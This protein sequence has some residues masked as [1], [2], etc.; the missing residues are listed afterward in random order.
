MT[1]RWDRNAVI[2]QIYPRS[3]FDENGDGVG[4]L[5]GIT[6]KL[7][8][9]ASLGVDAIWIS[10]FFKSP[11]KDFGYDV[12]DPRDVDPIFG[13]LDDF[14]RLLEAAHERDLKVLIDQVLSHTSDQ[15]EWF[16]ESR[17]S[18]TNARADWYVWVDPR[19]DGTP[20]N[21]WLSVFG[22]SAWQWEPR[23]GQYYLHNFLAEQ[24]D[25]NLHVDAVQKALLDDVRFWLDRGVDGFRLDAINF[26]F[27][28]LE[29]R[30]N[31]ALPL[32]R[33]RVDITSAANPHGFQEHV[34]GSNRPEVLDFLA[35]LRTLFDEYDAITSVG[36]IGASDAIRLARDYTAPGRLHMTYTFELLGPDGSASTLRERIE[37]QETGIGEGWMCWSVGNHDVT[38]VRSRWSEDG[39]HT[40]TYLTLLFSLRG[41]C[42]LYQGDELGLPE[43]DV[44][45]DRLQDPYGITFWPEFKGRD[46]CRTPIP[47]R[48]DAPEAGFTTATPWLPIPDTHRALAVDRQDDDSVLAHVRE[49]LA[50]RP[51]FGEAP[52]HFREAP[53][54]VL[55]FE[56]GDWVFAFNLGESSAE[57]TLGD[58]EDAG[59]P[60]AVSASSVVKLSPGEF[61]IGR[62]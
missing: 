6:E 46:G 7:D 53:N 44:P 49:F 1:S 15:H 32:E 37:A 14:D 45:Y 62:R 10:P 48:A 59:A 33:R 21:N 5:A 30:S 17:S 27:H 61:A 4:D 16:V 25:L 57:V 51:D 28:D 3:F 13:T 22:G 39:R 26:A 19:P 11:M 24:P 60:G 8:Y 23:R 9:V 31:P 38:R 18:K 50:W 42:C 29:L 36:E 56:R 34:Y 2:Y 41:A 43:A 40:R 47:W 58:V 35:E 55:C 52:T 54:D 12:A 20:P